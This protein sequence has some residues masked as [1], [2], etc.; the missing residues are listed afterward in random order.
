MGR[1]LTRCLWQPVIEPHRVRF[2]GLGGASIMGHSVE[3]L[4]DFTDSELRMVYAA[5]RATGEVVLL[6]DGEADTWRERTRE[7][8]RCPVPDCPSPNLTTVARRGG[9][10]HGFRHLS[11]SVTDGHLESLFH[12]QG[13]AAIAD[14]LRE[15]HLHSLVQ[16]EVPLD[17]ARTRVSDVHVTAPTGERAGIEIQYAGLTVKLFEQRRA[18]YASAGVLDVWLWGHMGAHMKLRANGTIALDAA[19][20]KTAEMGDHILWINGADGNLAVAVVTVR[21]LGTLEPVTLSVRDALERDGDVSAIVFPLKDAYLGPR[22]LR[23]RVLLELEQVAAKA[24]AAE[25]AE[26]ARLEAEHIAWVKE[27]QQLRAEREALERNMSAF[28]ERVDRRHDERLQAW[29]ASEKRAEIAALFDG[30]WRSFLDVTPYGSKGT[31]KTQIHLPVPNE[32]WQGIIYQEMIR[33][34]APMSPVYIKVIAERLEKMDPDVRLAH[35][36]A[37]YWVHRLVDAG[38][39]RRMEVPSRRGLSVRYFVSQ[40]GY[41]GLSNS[42]RRRLGRESSAAL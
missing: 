35:E 21:V 40:Q 29:R 1:D 7:Q 23:A 20:K 8:L 14:W 25:A 5:E 15:R 19:Q 12:L 32:E 9:W 33:G 2:R 31:R 27:Q 16:I 3:E 36:A 34:R 30:S 18:D 42:Q 39:L 41:T 13:K 26:R 11:G 38:V 6:P 10:R 28:F 22:G 17:E 4:R 24:L 37:T